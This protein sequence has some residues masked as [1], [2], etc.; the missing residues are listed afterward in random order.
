[1]RPPLAVETLPETQLA[2]ARERLASLHEELASARD[3]LVKAEQRRSDAE[4]AAAV[5]SADFANLRR[6]HQGEIS[7]SVLLSGSAFIFFLIY[8]P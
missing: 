3:A 1:M 8:F 2:A 6:E 4:G 5:V 7:S